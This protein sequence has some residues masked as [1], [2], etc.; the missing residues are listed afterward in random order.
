M[1]IVIIVVFDR[2]VRPVVVIFFFFCDR[3][4]IFIVIFIAK[5][6]RKLFCNLKMETAGPSERNQKVKQ[7][8]QG[9]DEVR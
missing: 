5:E 1:K 3:Y 4:L 6:T 8:A 9:D 7:P 2:A